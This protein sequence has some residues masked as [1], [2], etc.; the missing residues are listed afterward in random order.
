MK[1][2]HSALST[3]VIPKGNVKW[4]D[5]ETRFRVT[6]QDWLQNDDIRNRTAANRM[7]D[8]YENGKSIRAYNKTGSGYRATERQKMMDRYQ[9]CCGKQLAWELKQ[10]MLGQAACV[11]GFYTHSPGT[12]HQELWPKSVTAT[13]DQH[14]RMDSTWGSTTDQ[15]Y[16]PR[17]QQ[18]LLI[19][20]LSSMCGYNT[21]PPRAQEI[22]IMT[23]NC[24]SNHWLAVTLCTIS[25]PLDSPYV[26]Y[27]TQPI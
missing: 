8:T 22:I 27:K 17:V 19:S 26:D 9:G 23:Q 21:H 10:Q 7:L 12:R 16:D 15:N 18:Q 6:R 3:M 20:M 14:V 5:W 13:T 24:N 11:A 25:T 2:S 1:R 4:N